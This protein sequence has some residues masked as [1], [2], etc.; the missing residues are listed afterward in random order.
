MSSSTQVRFLRWVG[1][2]R[3]MISF[4][5]V[6]F[7]SRWLSPF[8][9][10]SWKKTLDSLNYCFIPQ[11]TFGKLHRRFEAAS[12]WEV[13]PSIHHLSSQYARWME[14]WLRHSHFNTSCFRW[15]FWWNYLR[16]KSNSLRIFRSSYLVLLIGF[17]AV[18]APLATCFAN[19]WVYWD[20]EGK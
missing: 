3:E 5:T 1:R 19:V 14:E 10:R 12:H 18:F 2:I 15:D 7:S 17:L 20:S 6:G 9:L 4:A 11:D 16:A 13:I 8:C